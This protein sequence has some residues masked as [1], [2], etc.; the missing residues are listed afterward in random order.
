MQ[1]IVKICKLISLGILTKLY[2]EVLEVLLRV[3]I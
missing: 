3:W 1:M 2:M